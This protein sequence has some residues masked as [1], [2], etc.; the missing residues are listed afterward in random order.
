MNYDI[1]PARGSFVPGMEPEF[2]IEN[3]GG[4]QSAELFVYRGPELILREKQ[5]IG[6]GVQRIKFTEIL[7][8]TDCESERAGENAERLEWTGG[9]GLEAKF[10]RDGVLDGIARTAFDMLQ[11]GQ[12]IRYGFLSD[13]SS[14]EED[15]EDVISMAKLH[16]NAVQFYDWSYRHD[17]LVAPMEQFTDMM[18]K[19]NDLS[20]IRKKVN[21]CHAYGMKALGY[22]AVYAASK[23]YKDRNPEQ[24]LY[25]TEGEPLCFIDT[26]YIMNVAPE[27]G[28]HQH[29]L[30]QYRQAVKQVDFDGIHMDTYGN[31]KRALDA[32]GNLLYLEE[33]FST[34]INHTRAVLAQE[35]KETIL[36]FNN[37]GGWPV[38]H[39][40]NA[41]QSA[42]YIEVWPPNVSYHHLGN[43]ITGAKLSGKS[44]ILA[45]Y[46]AAFR[47]DT[48][49]RALESQLL[50]SFVIAMYGATQLFF[51]EKNAVITQGYYADYSVLTETQLTAIRAYQDFFVQYGAYFYDP[52][53]QDVSMTHQGWDN[54]E[55]SFSPEGSADGQGGKIWYHIR[56][57]KERTVIYFLNL[58]ENNDLWNE[59]KHAPV[60]MKQITA[61]IQMWKE[62]KA[63]WFAEP[64][65]DGNKAQKMEYEWKKD[66]QSKAIQ[67]RVDIQR[68]GIIVTDNK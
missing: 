35:K 58:T 44:V 12:L 21:L 43:L 3:Y 6:R 4:A 49:K 13:F 56:Q 54:K 10:Y 46:P 31:P 7:A 57:S 63:V 38:E 16:I 2:L 52:S 66:G 11:E 68:C 59:G 62:P 17:Q 61:K 64:G 27:N 14:E 39:T 34:L 48:A 15:E 33:H 53:L 25:D 29:I 42:V 24:C 9:Y 36:I 8:G 1:Y 41:D 23:E 26:F 40:M 50:L 65:V 30:E 19:K 37:V 5:E 47:L 32:E 18:G 67:V 51:G 28:W 22:G 20:V 45:A 55:F 60:G